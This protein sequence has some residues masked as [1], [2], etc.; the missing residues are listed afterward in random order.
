ME[1]KPFNIFFF[2]ITII[3]VCFLAHVTSKASSLCN[4]SVEACS[5][6]VETEEMTVMME[7]WSSHR[8]MVEKRK[9]IS[10]GTFNPDQP[11]CKG[12]KVGNSY[13]ESCVPSSANKYKKGCSKIY[14]CV[15]D[16]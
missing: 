5:N 13:S 4:G 1:T 14:G 8:L 7:S 15:H 3:L 2:T 16:A 11:A 6:L 9:H 10:P 12:G